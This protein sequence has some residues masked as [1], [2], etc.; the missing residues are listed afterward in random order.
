VPQVEILRDGAGV[1]HVYGAT[2]RDLYF[3]LGYAV[4]EDRLWQ[5]DRLRR[6]ALGR[7]AE[8]LGAEYVR[9]D[10]THLTV[11]IDLLAEAD[12]A[13]LDG[14]I[15]EIVDAYV[16]GLNHYLDTHAND[17]PPEFRLLS[18]TPER[19]TTRDVIAILRGMWW[20]LNGRLEQ[21]V[22][23]EL[24]SR[25]PET[26]Q[27]AYLTPEAPEER[28][29]SYD[30]PPAHEGVAPLRD[31]LLGSGDATGSNNWAVAGHR[32]ASGHAMLCSDPHQPFWIP[33]S[34][35]EYVLHGPEDT[36]AGAGHPGVPGI[37]F[38]T[39][40]MIAWGI[41]NNAASTRDLYFEEVNP[42][43]PD[44]YR[45]GVG[46]PHGGAAAEAGVRL[47]R[48]AGDTWRRF[49]TRTVTIP[50]RGED[51]PRTHVIRST[52]RGPIVND[53]LPSV[54]EGGDPPLSLRWVG[55]EHLEDL[56]ALIDL[57]RAT[58]WAGFRD[59]L[60][61]WS[62]PAFNFVYADSA[63][64][65]GYQCAGRIP[66]RGRVWRGYRSAADPNDRWLGYVPFEALPR[67]ENPS[68][69]YVA[70]ANNRAA[71]DDFPYP[72]HGAWAAGY[73]AIRLRQF[74]AG[75]RKLSRDDMVALQTDVLSTRAERLVP[76]LLA[77]LD[78]NSGEDTALF[79]QILGAWDYRYTPDSA[80]PIVFEAFMRA[81][82]TRV[83]AE[84]FHPRY[85]AL[86]TAHGSAAAQLIERGQ[87]DDLPW[88]EG[89]PEVFQQALLGAIGEAL[90][91][92]RRRFH[93]DS[94][95]WSW[96]AAH[97]AHWRHPLGAP[98]GAAG[99]EIGPMQ[100]GG[101]A[102][103]VCNTGTG[104]AYDANSGAEYR[105]VV[106]FASPDR[107]WAVQNTGN[108]GVPGSP[109]Y[110]DQLLPWAKGEYHVVHL[111]LRAYSDEIESRSVLTPPA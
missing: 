64:R 26:L 95:R 98:D 108:S 74:L 67:E 10:L 13:R 7:Q 70:T 68:R 96:G 65:V 93:G 15:R 21:I 19:F 57:N 78:G 100:V 6:R 8:I 77:H 91:R 71:P 83:A 111:D 34:W 75:D 56:R 61:R 50:V 76:P 94:P 106:D 38:G 92:L 16:A 29:L 73:R 3:G 17:L 40:T 49:T 90:S 62:V 103:T 87:T 80:A 105:V 88:F 18:Y 99:W 33:G 51:S 1:P 55:Q 14:P 52:V 23:A 104:P 39:N 97:L 4:A 27:A 53:V 22:T 9:S 43:N 31:T 110:A 30:A 24:S 32:S 85:A 81:W 102:D 47:T 46:E 42:R 12:A 109:H 36:V 28:I 84:R 107:I 59:A 58:D 69:G 72:L 37:W 63:G 54:E 2:T 66:V 79:R 101:G 20:S 11:G 41:T 45:D 5:V 86:V 60:S 48:D 35:H 89:G 44:E 25:L 82:L